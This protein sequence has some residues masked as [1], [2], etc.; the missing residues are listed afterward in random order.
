MDLLSFFS[1]EPP[2]ARRLRTQTIYSIHSFPDA[3]V[4]RI[5]GVAGYVEEET[6]IA[7]LTGRACAAWSVRIGGAD[8]RVRGQ[9]ALIEAR[10][11]A[12][13]TVSDETGQA[14]VH[15][16]DTS[17]LL[18]FDVTETLGFSGRAP[19]RL[20][21]FLREHGRE[22]NRIGH[23]WRLSWQ[24]G[25][26]A[27]GQRVAVVGR[28]RREIDPEAAEGTYRKAATRLVMTRSRQDEDFFVSTFVGSLG[29]GGTA[30]QDAR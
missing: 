5:V 28:G 22:G 8:S 11:A 3:A 15:A 24:E 26:I 14:V 27:E 17:L 29:A 21:H 16:D 23:D 19:P 18:A 13:F 6:L 10:R 25:T 20:V 9:T 4:G 1:N 12:P 30:P 7:P 2:L